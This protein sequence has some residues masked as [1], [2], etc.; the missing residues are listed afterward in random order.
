LNYINSLFTKFQ[1]KLN[2]DLKNYDLQTYYSIIQE[3]LAILNDFQFSIKIALILSNII[4]TI[5]FIG[6]L[7]SLLIKFKKQALK[8]KFKEKL[9]E[10]YK[11]SSEIIKAGDLTGLIMGSTAISYIISTI[12]L[13]LI[14]GILLS[15]Y[16]WIFLWEYRTTLFIIILPS[17]IQMAFDFVMKKVI[18]WDEVTI[19]LPNLLQLYDIYLLII[20][21]LDGIVASLN[22]LV[23]GLLGLFIGL[24]RYDQSIIPEWINVPI[25]EDDVVEAFEA[26]IALYI[27]Y[28]NAIFYSFM[29]EMIKSKEAK[30]LVSAKKL[31]L[32][33][34]L[35]KFAE[36]GIKRKSKK[37]LMNE[38][39]QDIKEK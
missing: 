2:Y 36:K 30:T 7:I 17:F 22:R 20:S 15:K 37:R 31:W 8:A 12:F 25:L 13:T 6:T 9:I 29:D 19:R 4:V 28:N 14:F 35:K 33:Y 3:F 23:F 1:T 5:I 10:K 38:N 32:Y 39:H 27:L 21:I 18:L 24:I 26:E 11:N 16:F 34:L